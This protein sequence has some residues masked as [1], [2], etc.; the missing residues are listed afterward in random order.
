MV[1]IK[2]LGILISIIALVSIYSVKEED[3]VYPERFMEWTPDSNL[4]IG[5][6]KRQVPFIENKYAAEIAT[7]LFF[8]IQSDSNF[9][10]ISMIDRN[11]SYLIEEY[12]SEYLMK[13]ERYHANIAYFGALYMNHSIQKHNLKYSESSVYYENIARYINVLQYY[14]DKET[15]H[16][17]NTVQQQYWEFKIDSL[18]SNHSNFETQDKY[19]GAKAFFPDQPEISFEIDKYNLRKIFTLEKYDMRFRMVINYDSDIDTSKFEKNFVEFLNSVGFIETTSAVSY[20]EDG[21]Y[22]LNTSCID[23]V[24]NTKFYDKI[25]VKNPHFYQLTYNHS[26]TDHPD[27]GVYKFLRDQFFES[28]LVEPQDEYWRIFFQLEKNDSIPINTNRISHSA[29]KLSGDNIF[30]VKNSSDY[31]IIYHEAIIVEDKLIVPFKSVRH[32]TSEYEEVGAIVNNKFVYSM[33]SDTGTQIIQID[34]SDLKKGRNKV[35]FGYFAI[36]DSATGIEH[37]FGTTIFFDF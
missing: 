1:K 11:N 5:D 33:P 15:N 29:S 25:I 23:T 16:G 36:A 34:T 4:T 21:T 22:A 32:K 8:E 10:L 20:L 6:F 37:L 26:I 7:D 30:T 12:Y 2:L 19:S 24:S 3:Y 28:F 18:I 35:K 31:S 17:L 27:S 13:H 9:K 14:Y